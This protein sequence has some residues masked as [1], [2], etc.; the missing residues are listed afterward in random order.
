MCNQQ[1]EQSQYQIISFAKPAIDVTY[2]T[3]I[4]EAADFA[5]GAHRHRGAFIAMNAEKM[6]S[7]YR[8]PNLFDKIS[9]PIY[10]PDGASMLWFRS[11]R[12]PR[13]PGVE[14]WLAILRRAELNSGR[15]LIIGAAPEVSKKTHDQIAEISPKL[16]Y[17]CIDGFQSEEAYIQMIEEMKPD[18]VFVAM[19]SPRQEVLISRLQLHWLDC[20]YMGIGG[21]LDVLTGKVK[22][23]PEIYRRIGAEFLYRLLKEPR[24]G[25]RQYRLLIFVS[26]FLSGKFN[27]L[28]S[29]SQFE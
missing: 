5:F 16:T 6:L 1:R 13:I 19:G 12:S 29:K 15:V 3:S 27:R 10:Y 23:A 8:D 17:N 4:A 21:S 18:V 22:R 9:N 7:L 11:K 20:F 2:F 25:F 26:L 14:L 28:R 24:R